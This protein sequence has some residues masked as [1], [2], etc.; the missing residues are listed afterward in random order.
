MLYVCEVV[1]PQPPDKRLCKPA[2]ANSVASLVAMATTDRVPR[3]GGSSNREFD[4]CT[5]V[6]YTVMAQIT[7]MIIHVRL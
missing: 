4:D 7:D 2:L 3:T 6:L 1:S 5:I